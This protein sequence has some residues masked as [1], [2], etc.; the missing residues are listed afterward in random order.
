VPQNV[1]AYNHRAAKTP[2]FWAGMRLSKGSAPKTFP[3]LGLSASPAGAITSTLALV[4]EVGVYANGWYVDRT[5]RG[6]RTNHVRFALAGVRGQFG[7]F[8][9]D[10]SRPEVLRVF[11]QLLAG[12]QVSTEVPTGRALQPGIGVD[13]LL[14][15][16][17]VIRGQLDHRSVR[18]EPRD[19][20]GGRFLFA[21]VIGRR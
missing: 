3:D 9:P 21:I 18:E 8:Q 15:N 6:Q 2:E 16:G 12:W 11:G 13:L 19:L 1:G 5:A 4:G 14:T 20:S 10:R 7:R 17:L